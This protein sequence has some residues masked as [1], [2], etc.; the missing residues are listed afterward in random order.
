MEVPSRFG[1]GFDLH[2]A[3]DL[4]IY[5]WKTGRPAMLAASTYWD[6]IQAFWMRADTTMLLLVVKK[7][8]RL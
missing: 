6:A 5:Q 2:A 4:L 3:L 7:I 1:A 8:H